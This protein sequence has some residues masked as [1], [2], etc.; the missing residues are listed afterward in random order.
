MPASLLNLLSSKRRVRKWEGERE[1][2]RMRKRELPLHFHFS[3]F[4]SQLHHSRSFSVTPHCFLPPASSFFLD[5]CFHFTLSILYCLISL[6][7]FLSFWLPSLN[8][9]VFGHCF[10]VSLS[11]TFPSEMFILRFTLFAAPFETHHT[12]SFLCL[13]LR[14]TNACPRTD[15]LPSG[16]SLSL[17]LLAILSFPKKEDAP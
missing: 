5:F 1:R 8:F 9:R 3:I 14:L 2:V 4:C 6:F 13:F 12:P 15:S 16:I 10:T 17:S 11:Q 7:L